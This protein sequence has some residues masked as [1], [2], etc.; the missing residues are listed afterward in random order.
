MFIHPFGAVKRITT[1][2]TVFAGAKLD[3]G[4]AALF[5]RAC[6]N[7]HSETTIWPWYS[8]LPPASWLV[9][10]DVSQARANLNLSHWDEYTAVQREALL[11]VIAAAVRNH[12]MPPG[13]FTLLHPEAILSE[14]ERVRIYNWARGERRRVKAS[15]HMPV[16]STRTP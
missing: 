4:T 15:L 5:E 16:A 3:A 11:G 13:R 10:R 6:L 12:Q 2:R 14:P 7:C 1:P 9:E 8:Y